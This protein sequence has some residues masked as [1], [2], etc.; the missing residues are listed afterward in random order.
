MPS[1]R[2]RF[3]DFVFDPS[4]GELWRAGK[5]VRIESQPAIALA[6]LVSRSGS[7]VTRDELAASIWGTHTH[8]QSDAGLNYCIRQIRLALG[9]NPRSPAFIETIPR[10]GYRF[11]A[12]VTTDTSSRS[13]R[14]AIPAVAA[15]M[16]LAIAMVE[17]QPNNHHDVAIRLARAVHDLIF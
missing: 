12:P 6:H 1:I 9:D 15:A 14:R 3:A 2:T 10:R 5:P 4:S 8:V 7:V 17:S 11:I 13:W 16:L